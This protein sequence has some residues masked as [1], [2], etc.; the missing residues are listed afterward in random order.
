M[1]EFESKKMENKNLIEKF[2]ILKKKKN[3]ILLAHYYQRKEIQQIADFVGDSLDLSRKASETDADI[4]VFAGVHF[5]AETVKILNPDKKVLVPD[6]DAGCSLVDNCQYDDVVSWKEKYPDHKLVTYINCSAEVKTI[7]DLIC[8]SSNAEKIINSIPK[9]QP[10]LFA[11]DKNL[12]SY[13]NNK[14]NRNM[15]LWDGACIVHEAFSLQKIIDLKL[16][17]PNAKIIA[18]P[19]SK[20]ILLDVA[21]FIGST[22]QLIQYVKTHSEETIIVATEGGILHKMHELGLS[23]NLIPAPTEE[24]NSCACSECAFMKVNTLKKLVDCMEREYPE[25]ILDEEIISLAKQP[26][27]KMLEL[28]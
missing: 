8:T 26:I 18:H 3:A 11:P 14:L 16:E 12:G 6:L 9:D 27:H 19:E 13:L 5:M 1:S 17:F 7:S 23:A 10:I 24:E 20:S 25:I 4:I 28:S 2:E 22:S 15:V 21:D